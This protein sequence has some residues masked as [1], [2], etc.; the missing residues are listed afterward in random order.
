MLKCEKGFHSYLN[1]DLVYK[2]IVNALGF[3]QSK[4]HGSS[5]NT[6]DITEI[7]VQNKILK[8]VILQYTTAQS[9]SNFF[10]LILIYV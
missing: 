6:L 5:E 7:R 10:S 1:Y 2:A 4:N 9:T 8:Y 3:L